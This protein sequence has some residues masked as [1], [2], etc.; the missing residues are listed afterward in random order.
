MDGR[1]KHL[2]RLLRDPDPKVDHSMSEMIGV[3]RLDVVDRLCE[4]SASETF[5]QLQEFDR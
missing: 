2:S 3:P 4:E 5:T 1:L